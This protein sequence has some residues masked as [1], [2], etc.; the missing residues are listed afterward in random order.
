MGHTPQVTKGEEDH[1]YYD[2]STTH[3]LVPEVHL[4]LL[5]HAATWRGA[6]IHNHVHVRPQLKLAL[7]VGDRRQWYDNEERPPNAIVDDLRQE[8]DA[9]YRLSQSHLISQDT[10]LSGAQ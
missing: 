5:Y 6:V 3:L 7:P 9:L 8:C 10:T 2:H 1:D 4:V